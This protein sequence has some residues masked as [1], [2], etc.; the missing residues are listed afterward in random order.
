MKPYILVAVVAV[1]L[2]MAGVLAAAA[3]NNLLSALYSDP[4]EHSSTYSA[5]GTLNGDSVTGEA[6]CITIHENGAYHNYRFDANLSQ[7]EGPATQDSFMVIFEPGEIPSFLTHSGST[8][9]GGSLVEIYEGAVDGRDIT[10]SV[11]EYCQI[12]EY[13]TTLGGLTYTCTIIN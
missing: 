2:L 9:I 7:G 12:L 5:T 3:T 10:I 1:A 11:G 13:T 8:L 4:Y 6:A